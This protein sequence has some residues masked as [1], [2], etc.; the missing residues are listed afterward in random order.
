MAEEVLTR[1][2]NLLVEL[3]EQHSQ[4]CD[5]LAEPF[6]NRLRWI[7]IDLEFVGLE[8]IEDFIVE[9][10]N[11]LY[12]SLELDSILIRM[13]ILSGSVDDLLINWIQG[14]QG[15]STIASGGQVDGV[16]EHE[17]CFVGL[18]EQVDLLLP[19]LVN[20]GGA[21]GKEMNN[22]LNKE[23]CKELVKRCGGLPLAIV[24]L[25]EL[26][27][28]EE[29]CSREALAAP[30]IIFMSVPMKG[31]VLEVLATSYDELPHELRSCFLYLRNVPA[32]AKIEVNK[33]LQ[34]WVAESLIPSHDLP[35]GE[36]TLRLACYYLHVL[37][38]RSMVQLQVDEATG[39]FKYCR[40]HTLLRDVC[41]LKGNEE[42]LQ[43][44][45][46]RLREIVVEDKGVITMAPSFSPIRKIN[47]LAVYLGE[48]QS[49]KMQLAKLRNLETLENFDL[50]VFNV[51]DLPHL[52]NLRK[53]GAI[54][55]SKDELGKIVKYLVYEASE[56]LSRVAISIKYCDL[57]S[58][59]GQ[60]FLEKLLR[61]S[62]L[63]RDE[64]DA[65][66]QGGVF[67]RGGPSGVETQPGKANRKIPTTESNTDDDK[68][69]PDDEMG[70][71]WQFGL[72]QSALL[73]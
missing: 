46:L 67:I 56:L 60:T 31:R 6:V 12:N 68:Y 55:T 57:C 45:D 48:L 54:V 39:L 1:L 5:I 59:D 72:A 32:E 19:Y 70:C 61:C 63:L 20:E 13:D 26:M 66:T 69:V 36:S 27:Q 53:L 15:S 21:G 4:G 29:W 17:D 42:D 64:P 52:N 35:E 50:R 28:T 23:T 47:K 7:K 51:E 3:Q 14:D 33:L 2:A 25:G 44:M 65:T 11:I 58:E 34:L 24:Q 37:E 8:G 71:I 30:E 62:V 10:R 41:F 73:K 43:V 9:A 22:H 18:H 49:R 16:A 38:S 40:V